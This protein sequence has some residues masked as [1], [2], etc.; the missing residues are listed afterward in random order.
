[1]KKI[2][3]IAI[4]LVVLSFVLAGCGNDDENTGE[5]DTTTT[6]TSDKPM[7][8]T[9]IGED[10]NDANDLLDELEVDELDDLESD[11]NKLS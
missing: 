2:I 6:T 3:S 4:I 9:N 8:T 5:K 1:M 7:E 11:L 10:I